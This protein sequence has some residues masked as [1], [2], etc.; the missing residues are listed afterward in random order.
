[1]TAIIYY[2]ETDILRRAAEIIG[3]PDDL[4]QRLLALMT[5]I[6]DK[7]PGAEARRILEQNAIQ[8]HLAVE[9]GRRHGWTLS[10]KDF[11]IQC[12]ARRGH[13]DP[14]GF[15]Q[16]NTDA[17]DHPYFYRAKGHATAIAAHL[18]RGAGDTREDQ[19]TAWAAAHDLAASFPTDFPSW[20]FPGWT[21]LVV[22]QPVT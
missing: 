20:W 4:A 9:F 21:R 11:T 14:H 6:P 2:Q 10:A 15:F 13:H 8:H 3:E 19:I 1:M 22:Y 18:Y 7:G 5:P 17:L 12:L 16:G